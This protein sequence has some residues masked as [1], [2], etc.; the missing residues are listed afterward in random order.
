MAVKILNLP[1]FLAQTPQP[2][3]ASTTLSGERYLLRGLWSP[4]AGWDGGA[5]LLDLRASDGAT[6]ALAVP[7]VLTLDLWA[8]YKS[9]TRI[10]RGSLAVLRVS[11]AGDPGELDLGVSVVLRY[12]D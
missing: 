11:G 5:W 3:Q 4:R 9:D 2:W 1:E 8:T 6:L 10:P 12:T 7:L